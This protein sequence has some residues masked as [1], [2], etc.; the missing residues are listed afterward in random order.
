MKTTKKNQHV[1]FLESIFDSYS[2][3]SDDTKEKNEYGIE[4][5]MYETIRKWKKNNFKFDYIVNRLNKQ[6]RWELIDNEIVLVAIDSKYVDTPNNNIDG[7]RFC[8]KSLE[9]IYSR[10]NVFVIDCSY[11]D[12]E[13]DEDIIS[14]KKRIRKFG[15]VFVERLTPSKTYCY[16]IFAGEFKAGYFIQ[17]E[18][19]KTKNSW[20]EVLS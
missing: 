17:N 11:F 9:I 5:Q 3:T 13:G 10:T 14:I 12:G 8:K 18:N 1:K 6:H 7:V 19:N 2:I 20:A 4:K 16:A 15:G